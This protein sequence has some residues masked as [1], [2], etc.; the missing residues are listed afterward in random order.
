MPTMR[1]VL[2]DLNIH[3]RQSQH[4]QGSC[5]VES[6]VIEVCPSWHHSDGVVIRPHLRH[7]LCGRQAELARLI[8]GLTTVSYAAHV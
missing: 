4:C 8:P 5:F 7:Y 1:M 2:I 6:V 3:T